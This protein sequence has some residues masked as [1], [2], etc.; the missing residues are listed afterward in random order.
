[1]RVYVANFGAGNWGWKECLSTNSMMVMDDDR[2]HPFY[3]RGDREGY[4]RESQKLLVSAT[5]G[6][7][8][9]AVASRWYGLHDTFRETD[10]DLWIHRDGDD[11]WWTHSRDT[12][13][14]SDT[15]LDPQPTHGSIS[16]CVDLKEVSGW[17]NTTERGNRL[18]WPELHIRAR[19]F[20]T[21]RATFHPVLGENAA[22]IKALIQGDDPSPWHNSQA[23]VG[24]YDRRDDEVLLDEVERIGI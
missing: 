6:R 16:I 14:R 2:V 3:L 17:K 10:G 7:V 11:L 21:N 23:W 18:R 13:L 4:I 15:R 1:M 5:G 22:Y 20:L 24:R 8:I 12:P 19:N 9:P